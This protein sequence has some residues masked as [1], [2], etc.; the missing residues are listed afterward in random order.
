MAMFYGSVRGGRGRATRMGHASSGIQASA[1]SFDGSVIVALHV[2]EK[3]KQTWATIGLAQ[4]SS[5]SADT[6]LYRGPVRELYSDHVNL[7]R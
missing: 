6:I 4:G 7:G 3:T 2:D 1:Q 5:S